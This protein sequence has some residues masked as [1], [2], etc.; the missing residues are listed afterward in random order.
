MKKLVAVTLLF[1]SVGIYLFF[2]Y[3]SDERKVQEY[4]KEEYG[5]DVEIKDVS[6]KG[7]QSEY[8][9]EVSPLKHDDLE[10]TIILP[11]GEGEITDNY[12]R[13][14]AADKE[15]HQLDSIM[16][17]MKELGF[18]GGSQ[19]GNLKM[20][21]VKMGKDPSVNKYMVDLYTSSPIEIATFEEEQLDRYFKLLTL[22][23][24]SGAKINR[25]YIY[26]KENSTDSNSV[27]LNMD[28]L[29]NAN[30]K[31]DLLLHIKRFNWRFASYYQNKKWESEKEKVENERFKFGSGYADYWFNCGE[32]NENEEC[33]R[34]LV[35]VEFKDD[36]LN[37]ENRY[38]EEDLTSIFHFFDRIAP[39]AQIEYRL[40]EEGSDDPKSV[41][42]YK[43]KKFDDISSFIDKNFK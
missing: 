36:S 26:D 43:I 39:H 20:N 35:Q 41:Y 13:A 42:R 31:E 10:F 4:A 2:L 30:S 9:Y 19:N 23:K 12:S 7:F 22:L 27:A 11:N 24:E 37:K 34:I 40:I 38:L 18:K 21:F 3:P 33:S 8:E 29:K 32:V 6:N 14:L 17:K 5:I 16:P 1:A 15:L 28:E 25:V